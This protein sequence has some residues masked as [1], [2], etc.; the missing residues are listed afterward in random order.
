MCWWATLQFWFAGSF[1]AMVKVS[2]VATSEV[3]P[4]SLQCAKAPLYYCGGVAHQ[5]LPQ[6]DS[7]L[8][9]MYGGIFL[10]CV[11]R[12][13]SSSGG[14]LFLSFGHGLGAFLEFQWSLLLGC[15]GHLYRWVLS[16]QNNRFSSQILGW[17]LLST[18]EGLFS[19]YFRGLPSVC[20]RG[21]LLY[22]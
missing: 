11:Q 9:M 14:V 13:F 5:Y 17:L 7:S 10:H 3:S 1:L 2:L 6:C 8:G 22:V 20:G 4:L 15:D 21:A 18:C 19:V 16:S 12:I